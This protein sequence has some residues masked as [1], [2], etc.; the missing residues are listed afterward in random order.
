MALAGSVV[1]ITGAS[2]GIGAAV[3]EEL[4]RRGARVVATARRANA[5]AALAARVPGV[6][7]RPGDITDA[8]LAHMYKEGDAVMYLKLVKKTG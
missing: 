3:A 8:E 5:L 7:P 2:S 6:D 4:A 1:W